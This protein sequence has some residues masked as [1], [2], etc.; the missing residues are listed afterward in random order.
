MIERLNQ[1]LEEDFKKVLYWQWQL[2][3]VQTYHLHKICQVV[4]IPAAL[5]NSDIP[6]FTSRKEGLIYLNDRPINAETPPHLLNDEF[7]PDKHFFV[8]NNGT[9]PALEDIDVKNWTLE[10]SGESCKIL[11]LFY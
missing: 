8:R 1:L 11:Q 3:L 5:A 9:P 4:L 10:I 6:F 7:T 2:L